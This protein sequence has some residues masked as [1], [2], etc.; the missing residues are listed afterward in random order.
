LSDYAARVVRAALSSLALCLCLAT[1]AAGASGCKSAP[2][3]ETPEGAVRELVG[4][5]RG[6]RGSE[7]DAKALFELLS[8]RAQANLQ[9]RADRYGAASGKMIAPWAMLVPE[10]MLPRFQPQTYTAQVVGKYALV[11]VA[12]VSDGRRAQIPCVLENG[13]WR[14]DLVLPEL[15]PFRKRP[16][17]E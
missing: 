10:R 11:E 9:Q 16:G 1:A 8:Q 5:M 6:F 12:G 4:R 13:L 2:P 3:N 7:A 17:S 15:P 14:V